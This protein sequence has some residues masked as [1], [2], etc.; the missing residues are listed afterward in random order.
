MSEGKTSTPYSL[1]RISELKY[2]LSLMSSL[3]SSLSF[4]LI[5]ANRFHDQRRL[6]SSFHDLKMFLLRPLRALIV[7][8]HKV[9]RLEEQNHEYVNEIAELEKRLRKKEESESE[10][11]KLVKTLENS[12]KDNE[13]LVAKLQHDQRKCQSQLKDIS[14]ELGVKSGELATTQ[15]Q[16]AR[17]KR[18]CGEYTNQTRI[19]VQRADE[20]ERDV[21]FLQDDKRLLQHNIQKL[22]HQSIMRESKLR[23][24]AAHA[25]ILER[26]PAKTKDEVREELRPAYEQQTLK[27]EREL[28][29]VNQKQRDTE[30][31]LAEAKEDI[32]V[33]KA[34]ETEFATIQAE[35]V[36]LKG[37]VRK[38]SDLQTKLEACSRTIHRLER[39][40]TLANDRAEYARRSAQK[41]IES[42]QKETAS[43]Q[44]WVKSVETNVRSIISSRSLNAARDARNAARSTDDT[45]NTSSSSSDNIKAN[46]A[47]TPP[48][49]LGTSSS[50]SNDSEA[51]TATTTPDTSGT[52][53]SSPD[54]IKATTATTPPDTLGT[55]SSGSNDSKVPTA[56]TP[57]DTLGIHHEP[58]TDPRV[59][60]NPHYCVYGAQ[61]SLS[62]RR[63]VMT[64]DVDDLFTES[65]Y[66][67]LI[68]IPKFSKRNCLRKVYSKPLQDSDIDSLCAKFSG[69]TL[70]K[71]PTQGESKLSEILR[72]LTLHNPAPIA[73][74]QSGDLPPSTSVGLSTPVSSATPLGPG[75]ANLPVSTPAQPAQSGLSVSEALRL[76]R[77]ENPALFAPT[78]GGDLPPSTSV[79][80]SMPVG[81]ATPLGPGSANLPVPTPAQP[82]QGGLSVSEALRLLALY[83]SAPIAPAQ[84]GDLPPSTSVGPTVGSATPLGPGSANLP[85]PTLFY[86]YPSNSD[87][88]NSIPSARNNFDVSSGRPA[89]PYPSPAPFPEDDVTDIDSA[90]WIGERKIRPVKSRKA[91]MSRRRDASE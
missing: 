21:E 8:L 65:S 3:L 45:N 48:D 42:A 89:S 27:L 10:T 54:D 14:S 61:F 64:E 46:T 76:L 1:K 44:Q 36:R 22:D 23:K 72:N 5:V 88:Y 19:A 52:S 7:Y 35:N 24:V 12:Q 66:N 17:R 68:D 25:R 77:M 79:G 74:T 43:A 33:R 16:L 15:M 57:P 13:A 56:T 18:R 55:S 84:G 38:D 31:K 83:N 78:Q 4:E 62:S 41:E 29:E 90:T 69:L 2:L 81:S 49:T 32:E 37:Y 6:I 59:D 28:E 91:M 53:S 26:L 47:T 50:G 67:V 9:A 63:Q 87:P 85:V 58:T 60:Y 73:P 51:T 70:R 71:R 30:A 20:S 39:G 34:K 86:Q 82:A 11:E 80:P 75:S 40:I